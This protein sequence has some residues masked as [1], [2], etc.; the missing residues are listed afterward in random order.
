MYYNFSYMHEYLCI[1]TC[2]ILRYKCSPQIFGNNPKAI[3]LGIYLL[4]SHSARCAYILYTYIK[5]F[6][7]TWYNT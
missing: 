4:G 2:I 7:I 1:Y 3:L 5:N 6:L